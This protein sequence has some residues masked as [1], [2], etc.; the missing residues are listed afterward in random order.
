MYGSIAK[1]KVKPGQ[2]DAM[3]EWAKKEAGNTAGLVTQYVFQ[4]DADPDEVFL[5]VIF[6]SKDAYVA[7]AQSPEQH[8]RYLQYSAFL[9]SEPEWHDGTVISL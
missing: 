1:F 2:L 3:N 8:Q 6:E 5:V 4:Q 9:A 7:N